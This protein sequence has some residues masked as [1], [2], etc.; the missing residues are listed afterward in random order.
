MLYV[1]LAGSGAGDH[2]QPTASQEV[3]SCSSDEKTF[4]S[5]DLTEAEAPPRVGGSHPIR[6]PSRTKKV[7]ISE[8][9]RLLPPDTSRFQK[10]LQFFLGLP[11]CGDAVP[12]A[13]DSLH[14]SD[15][16]RSS[17]I[18]YTCC[19]APGDVQLLYLMSY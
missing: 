14:H 13:D 7:E 2:I 5:R 8:E 18:P 9:D 1:N 12:T 15:R 16:S 10:L 6:K 4:K 17:P 19:S 11:A 3:G